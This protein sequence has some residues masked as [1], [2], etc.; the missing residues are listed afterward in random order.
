MSVPPTYAVAGPRAAA[1]WRVGWAAA[2]V[3]AVFGVVLAAGYILW[4]V[5]R[6]LT[7]PPN[8][9]WSTL[10]DATEWWERAA[11]GAMLV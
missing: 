4:T 6:V 5:Q 1:A 10:P 2:T 3:A 8:E 7:G 11:M 9:R